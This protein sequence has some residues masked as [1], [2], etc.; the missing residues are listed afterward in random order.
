VEPGDTARKASYLFF[1]REIRAKQT[2]RGEKKATGT[3]DPTVP[4][5]SFANDGW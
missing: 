4:S 1:L 5:F 2:N 3:L